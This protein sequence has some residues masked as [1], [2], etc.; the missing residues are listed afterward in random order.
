[1]ERLRREIK[2]TDLAGVDS[3]LPVRLRGLLAMMGD[4]EFEGAGL[5]LSVLL[6]RRDFLFPV[7]EWSKW[8]SL[9]LAAEGE[10][11][12]AARVFRVGRA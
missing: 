7:A 5:P 6:P 4:S 1:M 11:L 10:E 8:R 3:M 9:G 12:R 2:P